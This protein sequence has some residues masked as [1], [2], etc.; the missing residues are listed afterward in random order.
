[1]N[2]GRIFVGPVWALGKAREIGAG[3]AVTLMNAQEIPEVATPE[4][5]PAENH[6]RLVMSDIDHP[7][8]GR[9]MPAAEH[10]RALLAFLPRWDGREA[11]LLIHCRAGVSRSPAA[12]FI[13]LCALN[14]AAD[15]VN[16]AR[17][18]REAGRLTNPN[19]L[20]VALADAELRRGGRMVAAMEVFADAGRPEEGEL[21]SFEAV[22]G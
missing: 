15:E 17:R 1:M 5:M 18:L 3:H 13:A 21:F 12:A 4:H 2:E 22:S 16:L 9:I 8:D 19:R 7:A 6:L 11:P 10:V 14:P 20:L